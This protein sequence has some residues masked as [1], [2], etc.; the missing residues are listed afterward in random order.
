MSNTRQFATNITTSND[1]YDTDPVTL[2]RPRKQPESARFVT[3]PVR[4]QA[5]Y[6]KL[7]PDGRRVWV[8][9]EYAGR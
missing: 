6:T 9:G 2:R 3:K 1:T 7:L 5:G 4:T 8:C